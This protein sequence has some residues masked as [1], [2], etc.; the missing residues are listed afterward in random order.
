MHIMRHEMKLPLAIH[1][2]YISMFQ[3]VLSA[4]MTYP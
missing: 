4:G 3:D 2:S 1:G